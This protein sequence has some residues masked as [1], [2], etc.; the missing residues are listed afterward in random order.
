ML[1]IEKPQHTEIN[2]FKSKK[3]VRR[4][5]TTKSEYNYMK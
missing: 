5:T 4:A 2:K 1:S 3:D